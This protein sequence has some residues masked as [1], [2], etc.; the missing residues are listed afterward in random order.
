[1]EYA[2]V[3]E[4]ARQ[5]EYLLPGRGG[6]LRLSYPPPP[7]PSTSTSYL[8]LLYLLTFL[9]YLL[10]FTSESSKLRSKSRSRYV[11]QMDYQ[12]FYFN[13]KSLSSLPYKTL[14]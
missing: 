14:P 7:T 3:S 2:R 1:M 5:L 12:A 6:E 13:I 11:V 9:P 8:I 4:V 10:Y